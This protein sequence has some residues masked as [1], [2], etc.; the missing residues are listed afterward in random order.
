METHNFDFCFK[1]TRTYVHGTD[2][3]NN[4]CDFLHQTLKGELQ[5]VD[6]TIRQISRRNMSGVLYAGKSPTIADTPAVTFRFR[7]EGQ[8]YTLILREND[9]Q[10]ACRYEYDEERIAENGIVS[11]T[12]QSIIFKEA[13]PFSPIEIIVALNKKLVQVL[14]PDRPGKWYFTRISIAQE[15][16]AI[17]GSTYAL[18]LSGTVGGRFARTKISIDGILIGEIYFSKVHE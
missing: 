5:D 9:F 15:L 14:L 10:I 17:P 1:G 6:M 2:I 3:Y 4:V 13:I 16:R 12:E 11:E 7:R 18:V 8:P